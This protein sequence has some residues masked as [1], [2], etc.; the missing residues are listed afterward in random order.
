MRKQFVKTIMELMAHD[1][2]LV[3]LLGDIGVWGFRE[4]AEKW[5]ARVINVGVCE[6]AMVSLAAGLAMEGLRPVIH[7]IAPFAVERCFEQLKDDVCYQSLPVNI[8][9]VGASYDYASLGCT[10]HAPGDVALLKTLPVM[11]IVVPGTPDEFDQLFKWA[12]DD[13]W[14]TY[15]RLSERC[16]AMSCSPIDFGKAVV[17]KRGT[18]ATV[19]AVGPMLDRVMEATKYLDVTVLYYTTVVPFDFEAIIDHC[20]SGKVVVV[21]PFYRGT[22][23]HDVTNVVNAALLSIGVPK[24]FMNH[25]GTAEENDKEGELLGYQ[26]RARIEEFINSSPGWGLSHVRL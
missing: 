23:A 13:L 2:R 19:I 20:R 12:Y 9:S 3:L 4:A 8:V 7:T 22:M 6:Q 10:H 14:P 25:Y 11:E 18:L 16:N 17:V 15:F 1:K 24:M 26:I 21:E 5:P